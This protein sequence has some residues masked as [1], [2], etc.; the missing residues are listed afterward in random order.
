M[1]SR[2]VELCNL[3]R[4]LLYLWSRLGKVID[5]DKSQT[6]LHE[7][8]QTLFAF[9]RRAVVDRP[10][11]RYNSL[12]G[13]DLTTVAVL[14]RR[15]ELIQVTTELAQMRANEVRLWRALGNAQKA[16]YQQLKKKAALSTY[17][18]MSMRCK[19]L[20]DIGDAYEYPV[21]LGRAPN[22]CQQYVAGLQP[23]DHSDDDHGKVLYHRP[24]M[25]YEL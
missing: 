22:Y 6:S 2:R 20:V 13:A 5:D 19:E 23:G 18:E 16:R 11:S 12:P 10:R 25:W 14:R 9:S 7:I 17:Y 21:K 1:F 15:V 8:V 3:S 4:A 24:C